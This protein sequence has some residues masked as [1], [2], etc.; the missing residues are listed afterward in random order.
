MPPSSWKLI[1]T[2]LSMVRTKTSAPTFT[3]SETSLETLV[4]CCGR[5]VRLDE[6]LVDVAGEEVRRG[7]RHDRRRHQRADADRREGH[8][9]EPVGEH[10]LEQLRDG[11]LAVVDR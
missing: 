10:V 11:E 1:A 2:V 8:A 4:S 7:D 5:R 3:S 9:R 6:V